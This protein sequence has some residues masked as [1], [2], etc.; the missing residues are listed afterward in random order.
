[1]LNSIYK[2][3]KNYNNNYIYKVNLN[4]LKTKTIHK[5]KFV[6]KQNI[7]SNSTKNVLWEILCKKN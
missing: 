3:L 5:N 6:Q 1:M 2:K 4:N 7:R